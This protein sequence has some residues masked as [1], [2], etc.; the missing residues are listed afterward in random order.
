[1][2]NLLIEAKRLLP[3]S[4]YHDFQLLKEMN[5][6]KRVGQFLNLLL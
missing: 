4:N 2:K 6:E 5:I 1:M 3:N